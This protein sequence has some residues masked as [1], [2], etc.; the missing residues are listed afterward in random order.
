MLRKFY[1]HWRNSYA[2]IPN[3]IWFLAAVSLVN[4]CGSMVIAFVTLYLTQSLHYTLPEAGYVMGCFGVGA[5]IGAFLGGKMTDKF[6]YYPVQLWSLVLNGIVLLLMMLVQDIWWMCATV[7]TLSFVSEAFRPANSVAISRYSEPASRTRSISLY[8]M[9]VNLGWTVAPVLGGLLITAFGWSSLFWADGLTCILAALLLR[10]RMPRSV[11]EPVHEAGAANS[12]PKPEVSPYR[13]RRYLWFLLL[14]LLNGMVFMQI[15][16]TVP[17]FFK[18]VYHWTEAQIG[19]ATALNGFIVFTVEMPLI[20]RLEG[21]RS[22]LAWVRVGLI[23]YALAYLMFVLPVAGIVA[24]MLFMIIISFGEI[25]VMPFSSNFVYA[26]ATAGSRQGQYM[27][28]YTMA[29]SIS[30]ILAPLYGT[31]MIAHLGYSALW[32]SLTV[33]IAVAWIGIWRMERPVMEEEKEVVLEVVEG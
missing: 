29:Y 12:T 30:N 32:S 11:P 26:R 22:P 20:F 19:L 7:F 31:Q 10:W 33:V 21:R 1:R 17:V 4:R 2:G 8:R 24:G 23:L 27:A 18:E 13:D 16:W 28:L 5:M 15:L 6:G 14:T 25:F 3:T 9:A